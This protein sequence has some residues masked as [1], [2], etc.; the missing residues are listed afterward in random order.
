MMKNNSLDDIIKCDI[1]ISAPSSSD[2]SFENILLIVPGPTTPSRENPMDTV[3]TISKADDLLDYGYLETEDAYKA[4][5]VAFDQNP[6]PDKL[7]ICARLPKDE[8][9]P[10][11]ME[12]I[13]TTLARADAAADFYGVHLTSYKESSDVLAAAKWAEANEKLFGFEY[14]DLDSCPITEATYFRTFG[15]YAGKADGYAEE[16]QPEQNA[17]AALALMAMCFCYDP[18]TETWHL[19]QL[20][21]IVSSR[22]SKEEKA[23]LGEKNI[24]TFLRYAGKDCTVGGKT[25]AGEWIDVIRFRD[26]LKLEMQTNIFNAMA[27]NPKIP[28]TDNGIGLI[29]GKMEETLKNGQD[30]GGIAPSMFDENDQEIPGYTVSVPKAVSLT[31]E[32]RKSRTLPN[33]KYTA[34]L[35]GAIHLV[36]IEGYLTF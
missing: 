13:S 17:F 25:I 9:E 8:G 11:A 32:Q 33:C 1:K 22:L 4:A 27:A 3:V 6:A 20:K 14:D 12:D 35:S 15:V 23:T 2:T 34:R 19:K 36:E 21:D 29:E 5:T 18:G 24:T 10:D 30:I 31:E 7:L 16:E 26:W 28:F